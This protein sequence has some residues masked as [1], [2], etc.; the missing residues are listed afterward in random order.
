MTLPMGTAASTLVRME[1]RRFVGR[2]TSGKGSALKEQQ[3]VL[4]GLLLRKTR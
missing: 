1:S 2:M 3:G 4:Y